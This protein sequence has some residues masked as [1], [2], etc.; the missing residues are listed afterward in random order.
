VL[1]DSHDIFVKWR[2]WSRTFPVPRFVCRRHVL[3]NRT[4]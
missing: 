2:S 3:C 4:D 1:I